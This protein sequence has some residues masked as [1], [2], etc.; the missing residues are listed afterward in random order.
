MRRLWRRRAAAV[1][2][3][4]PAAG[5]SELQGP[6][7]KGQRFWRWLAVMLLVTA[8]ALIPQFRDYLTVAGDFAREL[9]RGTPS[10]PAPPVIAPGTGRAREDEKA[11][12]TA[13]AT[14][15]PAAP[16]SGLAAETREAA[17]DAA[18]VATPPPPTATPEPAAPI[19]AAR[20][21][22]TQWQGAAL[23]ERVTMWIQP[24]FAIVALYDPDTRFTVMEPDRYHPAYPVLLD[25]VEWVRVR[26]ADGLAGWVKVSELRVAGG[27]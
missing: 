16:V 5:S 27:S 13:T 25:G 8:V 2:A 1:P 19:A 6:A 7:P 11:E 10:V 18:P 4:P 14:P 24:G 21:I 22:G 26:A 3:P 23:V 15:Q 17:A 20:A 12:G 9:G